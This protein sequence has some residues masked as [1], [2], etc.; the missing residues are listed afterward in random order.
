[1]KSSLAI[2]LLALA[3]AG[4]ATGPRID[5]TYTATYQDS[6]AQ[7]LVIHFTAQDFPTALHTLTQQ[8]V[9]SHYLVRDDPP[10]IYRL[11]DENR[12]AWHAGLSSWKGHTFLNAASI[13]IE[14]VNMGDAGLGPDGSYPEYPKAQIDAVVALVKDIVKRHNIPP[15]RVVGHSDIAPQ[16][17]P[18]PGPKFPWKR[19]ADEGLVTWPDPGAVAE[20]RAQHEQNLPNVRWFQERL[21]KH[22]FAVPQ[23]GELDAATRRVVTA[24]Q[25]KY[26]PARYD[27]EPDAETAAIL[28]VLTSP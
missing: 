13:G 26:R 7:F 23:T 12:R 22:G 21:E 11:V 19:L 25:M 9:S 5:D 1:M 27:G 6:R 10:T 15:D 14:I 8:K 17:K 28:D 24:F 2:A 3:L 16:R 20:R 4:C 18:D